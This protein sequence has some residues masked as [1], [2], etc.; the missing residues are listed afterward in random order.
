MLVPVVLP[1]RVT[2]SATLP[3]DAVADADDAMERVDGA[4]ASAAIVTKDVALAIAAHPD[5]SVI[6]TVNC[7]SPSATL[8]A[9]IGRVMVLVVAASG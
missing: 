4:P 1:P 5:T 6:F 8:S 3:D 7:S 2:V 9:I